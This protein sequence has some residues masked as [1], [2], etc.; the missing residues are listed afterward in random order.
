MARGKAYSKEKYEEMI[1]NDINSF[2]RQGFS[3]PRLTM[4]SVTR[5][6]L[7][8]DYSMAKVYWDT[9]NSASRGDSKAAVDGTVGKIRSML[10]KTLKVRHVPEIKFFYDSQFE[11][12]RKIME[13]LQHDSRKDSHKEDEEESSGYLPSYNF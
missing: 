2:L 1:Q 4:V 6:E 7:N 5:V 3:D 13:L 8:D 10:A 9:F 11:D 12:E